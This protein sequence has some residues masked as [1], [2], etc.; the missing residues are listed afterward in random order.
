MSEDTQ[1][2]PIIDAAQDEAAKQQLGLTGPWSIFML[3]IEAD[4]LPDHDEVRKEFE[5][6]GF[7][8]VD[9]VLDVVEEQTRRAR[10]PAGFMLVG[11]LNQADKDAAP[12]YGVVDMREVQQPS[13]A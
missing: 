8:T 4:C 3:S 13:A 7:V 1:Y 11:L 9:E 10:L 2:E 6:S 12:V 5:D